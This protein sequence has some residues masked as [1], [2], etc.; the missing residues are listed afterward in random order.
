MIQRI[1]SIFLFLAGACAL[2]LFALPLATT[3]TAQA[4]SPLF[5]DAAFEVQ[6][7]PTMMGAFGLAGL[8]LWVA[9][10]LY[11][12]RSLQMNITRL[13]LFLAGAGMGAAAYRYFNDPA[14]SLAQP[15]VGIAFPVLAILFGFLA[16]RNIKKDDKLVKS[17]DRLR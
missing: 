13:G 7:G 1:Q 15:A 4:S 6:D 9:I 2:V 11:R 12:N 17:I 8:G 16:Y 10:F 5:A 14:A 3:P